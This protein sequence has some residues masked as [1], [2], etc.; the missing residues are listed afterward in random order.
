MNSKLKEWIVGYIL[1]GIP[2]FLL[3]Y[4]SIFYD[5]G[6]IVGTFGWPL[7]ILGTHFLVNKIC[8]VK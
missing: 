1:F 5:W 3:S 8:K 7:L 2:I 6:S 4:G